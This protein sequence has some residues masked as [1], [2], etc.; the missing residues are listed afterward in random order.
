MGNHFLGSPGDCYFMKEKIQ[1]KLIIAAF[2]TSLSYWIY[3]FFTSTMPIVYDS[4]SYQELGKLIHDEGLIKY[5]QDGPL[6]EPLYPFIV[7]ISMR[8]G[9]F[10]SMPFQIVLKIIQLLFLF[11]TQI[12]ALKI[13]QKL[14]IRNALI[15][16]CILYLG[17]S[18][19]LVNSSLSL[20]S[21]I[22]TYPLIL[23]VILLCTKNSWKSGICLG[24]VFVSLTLVKGAFEIITP[25]FLIVYI[26]S[27]KN[28]RKVVYILS[29]LIAFYIPLNAYKALN[30]K[31]NENFTLT[32]FRA[33]ALYGNTA[34]RMEASTFRHFLTALAYMPGEGVCKKLFKETECDFWSYRKSDE[35]GYGIFFKH[36]SPELSG[37][38]LNSQ[39]ITLSI[40]EILKNPFQ[41]ALYMGIEGM[42][43]F[44][45]EST[46]IGYVEYPKGLTALFDFTLFKDGIR[47]IMSF[48]TFIA[49]LYFSK[50]VWSK[51]KRTEEQNLLLFC[52]FV[53][54][55][56]YIAIHSFF[57][58]LTRYVLPI[59]PLYLITITFFIQN[60]TTKK[61][62]KRKG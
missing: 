53:L 33:W 62:I 19:A 54:I 26:L 34:R 61:E 23:A 55:T 9:G 51:Q 15:S 11:L 10:F 38:D 48:L 47:L 25:L 21:E 30:D 5:F 49:F 12:L 50:S 27:I 17:F 43:M 59:A 22:I 18:P 7:S 20:Y 58:V 37:S 31:Y 28:K 24:L 46:K 57:F 56:N 4:I 6:R 14:K 13:L 2:A 16:L 35:L 3:L 41:Y 8:I 1:N 44:F 32:D 40:N 60:I 45:W 42:K 39:F 52:I 29:I 36:H